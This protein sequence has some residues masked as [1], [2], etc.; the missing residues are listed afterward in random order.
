MNNL[1]GFRGGDPQVEITGVVKPT[2]RVDT[3][4]EAFRKFQRAMSQLSV[5]ERASVEQ[6]VWEKESW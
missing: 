3:A 5:E 6:S 2:S 4:L 1:F